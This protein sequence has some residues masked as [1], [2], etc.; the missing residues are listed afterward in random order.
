MQ[1]EE[2]QKQAQAAAAEHGPSCTCPAAEQQRAEVEKLQAKVEE[3]DGYVTTTRQAA[4]TQLARA[5]ADAQAQQ[6]VGV[7]EPGT[8]VFLYR[9]AA[10]QCKLPV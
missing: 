9:F 8:L 2:H 6:Q 1:L 7:P 4:D 10:A 3:L 5:A